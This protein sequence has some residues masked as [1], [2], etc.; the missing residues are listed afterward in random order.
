MQKVFC[1]ICGKEMPND[2]NKTVAVTFN[3]FQVA[4]FQT[5]ID[6]YEP[7]HGDFHFCVPCAESVISSI[8]DL[9]KIAKME[10]KDGDGDGNSNG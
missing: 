2:F 3:C 7:K 10:Q 6:G 5:K 8:E 1:D 9:R 4:G